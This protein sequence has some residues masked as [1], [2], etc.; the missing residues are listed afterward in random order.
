[1][2][3]QYQ[4][5]APAK[6]NLGLKI[7]AENARG[8]HEIRTI[9]QTVQLFDDMEIRFS[10]DFNE[11]KLRVDGPVDVPE[12]P[13]NLILQALS[14][15][16]ERYE[17][18]PH[19]RI[20]LTKHIPTGAG[21]GG[22]SSDAAMVLL[23]AGRRLS[24]S[25][26]PSERREVAV[27]LGA[28][29]PFFLEGGTMLGEGIGERLTN[30]DDFEGWAVIA[31]PP[32]EID[33][34]RAYRQFKEYLPETAGHNNINFSKKSSGGKLGW[35]TLSLRN[36]FEPF[37]AATHQLH[38]KVRDVMSRFSNHLAL[39]G[40][41]SALYSLY[42]DEAEAEACED[43]IIDRFSDVQCFRRQLMTSDRYPLI[44]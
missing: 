37:V 33:T 17:E 40:S 15:F 21:L 22:G 43:E 9:F 13:D 5:R 30:V 35:Q 25:I 39:S 36:D 6:L 26:T 8:F 24:E 1:M 12:G 34:D 29:V 28:D 31:V 27:E 41:G 18:L 7:G 20:E 38:S 14:R 44:D 11:D 10:E 23:V 16:R 3:G 32:Y 42:E 2:D 19:A 4:V